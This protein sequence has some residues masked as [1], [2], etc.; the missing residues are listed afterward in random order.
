MVNKAIKIKSSFI[1]KASYSDGELV[2][3]MT[4]NVDY[5]F[6]DMPEKVFKKIETMNNRGASVGKFFN[7]SLKGKY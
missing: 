3:R 5:H 7:R 2:L 1:K 4:N 6:P